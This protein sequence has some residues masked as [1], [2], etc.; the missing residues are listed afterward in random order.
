MRNCSVLAGSEDDAQQELTLVGGEANTGFRRTVPK[1]KPA[2][3]SRQPQATDP[4]LQTAAQNYAIVIF[5]HRLGHSKRAIHAASRDERLQ[6]RNRKPKL[7]HVWELPG[8][9]M[10]IRGTCGD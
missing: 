6:E 9:S 2:R 3:F 5:S 8:M 1:V 7:G 4:K 10:H